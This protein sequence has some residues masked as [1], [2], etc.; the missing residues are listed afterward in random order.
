MQK[1]LNAFRRFLYTPIAKRLGLDYEDNEGP[2]ITQLRTITVSGAA[3]A[4][5]EAVLAELKT[6]FAKYVAGDETAVPSDLYGTTFAHVV[7]YGGKEEYEAVLKIYGAGK[8]PS[9]H[10]ATMYVATSPSIWC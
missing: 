5:E 6:R 1:Q 7:K 2:D 4:G 8:G 3:A 10:I 9:E